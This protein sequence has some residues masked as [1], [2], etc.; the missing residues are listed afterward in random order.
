MYLTIA[1]MVL[2][3]NKE[4]FKKIFPKKIEEDMIEEKI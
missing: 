3:E 4:T 2:K 1:K